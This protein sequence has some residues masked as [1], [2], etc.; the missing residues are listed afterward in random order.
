MTDAFS[1]YCQPASFDISSAVKPDAQNQI[2]IIGTHLS[3]N[4]LG[5]GGLLGPVAIYSER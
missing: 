1:G 4:E 3:L 5:T 2:T